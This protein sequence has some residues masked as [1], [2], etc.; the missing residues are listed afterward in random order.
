MANKKIVSK[1]L[2][3]NNIHY[4]GYVPGIAGIAVGALSL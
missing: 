2:S 3:Y 1:N 4:D